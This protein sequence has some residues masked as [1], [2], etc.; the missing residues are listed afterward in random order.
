MEPSPMGEKIKVMEMEDKEESPK[1]H[2][3]LD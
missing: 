3:I 2:G 1:C